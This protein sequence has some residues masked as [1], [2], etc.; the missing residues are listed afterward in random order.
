MINKKKSINLLPSSTFEK[1]L[2]GKIFFLVLTIGRYIIIITE[3]IVIFAFLFRFKLDIE[4]TNLNESINEKKTI[5]QN[6]Q[7]I[8]SDFLFLQKRLQII[9]DLEGKQLNINQKI[10][11]IAKVSPDDIYLTSLEINSESLSFNGISLSDS[12]LAVLLAGLQ[13]NEHFDQI[14]LDNLTTGGTN[15]PEIEFTLKANINN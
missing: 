10:E 15:K 6:Y 5:I 8:E 1:T 2:A 13:K 11:D 14:N 7:N 3:A 12:S 4:L 9:K